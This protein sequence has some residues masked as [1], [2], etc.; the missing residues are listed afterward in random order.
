MKRR[1]KRVEKQLQHLREQLKEQLDTPHDAGITFE[2]LG[3][4]YL[5][6]DEAHFFKN[7]GLPTNQEKL[8]VMPSQRA[9]DMLMKL[10]WLEQQNGKRPFASFFTATPISNSMVEAVRH[11]GAY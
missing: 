2:Q 3:I 9:Q 8:Q 11:V 5:I 10:R 6:V 4:S 7:L 1:I